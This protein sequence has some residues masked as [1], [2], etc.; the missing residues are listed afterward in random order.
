MPWAAE[1]L[2]VAADRVDALET[3]LSTVLETMTHFP[4]QSR[5]Y[6]SMPTVGS[7]DVSTAK[8]GLLTICEM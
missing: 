3:I 2:I 8:Y 6:S 7:I 1:Y 5:L 4:G